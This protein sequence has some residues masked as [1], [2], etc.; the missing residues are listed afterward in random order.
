MQDVVTELRNA[1]E[2][3]DAMPPEDQTLLPGWPE[4]CQWHPPVSDEERERHEAIR[5]GAAAV[6]CEGKS[7][8]ECTYVA[9][10]DLGALVRYIADMLE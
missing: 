8:D 2:R 5:R 3:L 7:P 6:L 9:Y 1:A 4:G 10:R